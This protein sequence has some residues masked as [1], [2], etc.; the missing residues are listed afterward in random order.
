[1]PDAKNPPPLK[2]VDVPSSGMRIVE[3]D[4]KTASLTIMMVEVG[5]QN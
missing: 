4:A 2:R 1:M 5:F 3:V